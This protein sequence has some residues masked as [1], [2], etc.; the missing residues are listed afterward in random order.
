MSRVRG[1]TF[2]SRSDD[3][4]M[5]SVKSVQAKFLGLEELGAVL[6]QLNHDFPGI[7][8]TCVWRF[9]PVTCCYTAAVPR[10][11]KLSDL[12]RDQPHLLVVPP[13]QVLRAALSLYMEDSSL[14]MPTPEEMLICNHNTTAE[15]VDSIFS[16]CVMDEC[17]S[18]S[19]C[20]CVVFHIAPC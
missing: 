5:I 1:C 17:D 14:P 16:H 9:G 12:K 8:P 7:N 18:T 2:F 20:C 13:D 19:A 4:I 3:N 11:R 10:K 6:R 15:E